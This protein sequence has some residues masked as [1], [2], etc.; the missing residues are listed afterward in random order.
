VEV[1]V[2]GFNEHLLYL[3]YLCQQSND[4]LTTWQWYGTYVMMTSDI[5]IQCLCGTCRVWSIWHDTYVVDDVVPMWQMGGGWIRN[6]KFPERNTHFH[7]FTPE[8]HV[9][10]WGLRGECVFPWKGNIWFHM[11]TCVLRS[12]M[13]KVCSIHSQLVTLIS[14]TYELEKPWKYC[15]DIV[16]FWWV[17]ESEITNKIKL[18]RFSYLYC[19][20]LM[21]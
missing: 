15:L 11:W 6:I 13:G 4:M 21:S 2:Q 18:S 20:W 12:H 17:C 14:P 9:P 10:S 19:G 5:A 8:C 3:R 1:R 7:V 16:A